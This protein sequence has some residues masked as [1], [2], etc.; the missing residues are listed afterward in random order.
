MQDHTVVERTEVLKKTVARVT[1]L[2]RPDRFNHASR[3]PV[4]QFSL[5]TADLAAISVCVLVGYILSAQ[6]REIFNQPPF[7]DY[8][9]V[10]TLFTVFFL[11]VV[12]L[13]FLSMWRNHYT[14]FRTFWTESLEIFQ[15]ICIMG[16][17]FFFGMFLINEHMS[18]LWIMISWV[19]LFVLIPLFRHIVKKY[20][21]KKGLWHRPLVVVGA[22][23]VSRDAA[24]NLTEDFY[25]G[26]EVVSTVAL[27]TDNREA[28]L[29]ETDLHSTSTAYDVVVNLLQ[30]YLNPHLPIVFKNSTDFDRYRHLINKLSLST[31]DLIIMPPLSDLPFI[32]TSLISVPRQKEFYIHFRPGLHRKGLRAV[33]RLFDVSITMVLVIILSPLILYLF[34]HLYLEGGVPIFGHKRV[35]RNGKEFYC[36]KFR[37]MRQ[38]SNELLEN[39]LRADPSAREEWESTFKLKNDPRVTSIGKFLRKSSMDELPQLWN[40]LRGEMSLVGPRPIVEGEI[41][42]YGEYFDYYKAISPGLTGLWQISGRNDVSY[43]ERVN[44]DVWYVRNWSLWNDVVILLS[45]IPV[46]A[47]KK[48]AY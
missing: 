35:G 44:L 17:A 8:V 30:R 1:E 29:A 46:L 15:S 3:L 4:K 11:P 2:R 48:G 14:E 43:E 40:I 24:K 6:I 27:T 34:I 39:Y 23:F 13:V 12:V 31:E 32:G 25:L 37:S 21:A 42:K 18:R 45:T 9:F 26:Y 28:S 47:G 16:A 10:P 5:I 22:G 38:N 7:F 20:L 41:K 36:W 33:K 19:G